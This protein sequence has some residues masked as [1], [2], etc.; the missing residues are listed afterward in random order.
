[1]NYQTH[2]D[3]LIARACGRTIEGYK[4]R[5]HIVP[6]CMGGDDE[7]ENIVELTAE[8]HYVAHQLLVKM[9]PDNFG[10]AL[11]ATRMA[12]QCTGNKAFGWLRRRASEAI[13]AIH[14]GKKHRKEWTDKIAA[15]LRGK[16]LSPESIAKR[17]AA[18]CGFKFSPESRAKLS[19]ARIGNKNSV[20]RVHSPETRA[21]ISVANR[22]RTKPPCIAE[23]RLK[24]AAALR[25]KTLSP[26][27]RAN[28]AAGMK[29]FRQSQT[30]RRPIIPAGVVTG[31]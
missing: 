24:L 12:K 22:G 25:G 8:E 4:E 21:K 6:R 13:S 26:E 3:R 15:A 17:T 18:R 1:V 5:H 14:T 9:H 19:A 16:P 10:L 27:H 2:Y 20:G 31:G 23:T 28:I 7:L 11:A 30:R 29:A